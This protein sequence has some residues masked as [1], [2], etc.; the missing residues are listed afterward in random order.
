MTITGFVREIKAIE[1]FHNAFSLFG[2]DVMYTQ[3]T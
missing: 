3:L 1:S 2:F